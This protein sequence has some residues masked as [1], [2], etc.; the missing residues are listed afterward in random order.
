MD[1]WNG[2][3]ACTMIAIQRTLRAMEDGELK[4]ILWHQGCSDAE[5]MENVESYM[6]KLQHRNEQGSFT[7]EGG[8][9]AVLPKKDGNNG[10]DV[11]DGFMQAN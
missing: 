8:D 9:T 10:G 4:A 11:V 7:T 5:K 6:P 2:E 3:R 1:E